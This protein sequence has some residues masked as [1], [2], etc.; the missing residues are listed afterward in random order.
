MKDEELLQ[1]AV[2]RGYLK[3]DQLAGVK[4]T[5]EQV[6]A[7]GLSMNLAQILVMKGLLTRQ[8]ADSL[9]NGDKAKGMQF[10]PYDIGQKLGEGGMGVVYK[11][12]KNDN[13]GQQLALKILHQRALNNEESNLRL[14][15]EAEILIKMQHP[16]IV[17]GLDFGEINGRFYV[18]MEF[19][20]GR[21]IKEIVKEKSA[22]AEKMVLK[23]AL[24]MSKALEFVQ[25]QGLVHRDIKPDNIMILTDGSAKLMDLGLAKSAGAEAVQLTAPGVAMGT[26]VY[27]STEQ[28]KGERN[29]DIRTD[30]YSLGATLF[31]A[32]TGQKPFEGD[33]PSEIIARKLDK[34]TPNVKSVRVDVSEGTAALLLTMMAKKREERYQT[35]QELAEE[36][37]RVIN[38][39]MPKRPVPVD[40]RK[41]SSKTM[42]APAIDSPANDLLPP[43]PSPVS[44]PTSLPPAPGK[45]R[46]K[47]L[48]LV[49]LLLILGCVGA[50]FILESKG[51]SVKSLFGLEE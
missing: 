43:S 48:F 22:L 5:A 11:A 38:G 26:P 16:N 15:R 29:L 33:K 36:I 17:R 44:V 45:S 12:T 4:Q 39:E 2:K 23:A 37:Q 42:K 19:V 28:V 24:D 8:Q 27:M 10:G 7:K 31:Y 30:I 18:A 51:I 25:S 1:E 41:R 6:A 34:A 20:E 47:V 13:P 3:E 46:P 14:K 21:L 50:Y 32:L 35:P 9:S 40:V 49:L